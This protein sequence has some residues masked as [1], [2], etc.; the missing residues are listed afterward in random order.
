M[1]RLFAAAVEE[2]A[3]RGVSGTSVE[4]ICARAG[5]SRG[6]FY[7]NFPDM[8][9]LCVGLVE[10]LS[11]ATD[12]S[13]DEQLDDYEADKPEDLVNPIVSQVLDAMPLGSRGFLAISQLR[14]YSVSHPAVREAFATQ[15]TS[16]TSHMMDHLSEGMDRRG[17]NLTMGM[18]DFLVLCRAYIEQSIMNQFAD[19]AEQINP[20]PIMEPLKDLARAVI[21]TG[22]DT[23]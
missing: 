11:A 9:S 18:R 4:Q 20:E 14:F 17:W 5:F 1:R 21:T 6:A 2:F 3:A 22:N 12:D 8:N 19:G 10:W 23:R 7:S 16:G 13:L 15:R